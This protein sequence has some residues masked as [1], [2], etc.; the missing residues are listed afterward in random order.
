[1]TALQT[2][3]DNKPGSFVV[4]FEKLISGKSLVIWCA[5]M[6]KSGNWFATSCF[7]KSTRFLK[8]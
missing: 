4:L 2:H 6:S 7:S 5:G 8:L 1:M 3:I